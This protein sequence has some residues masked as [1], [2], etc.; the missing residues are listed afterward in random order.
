MGLE[1]ITD[2]ALGD[3]GVDR[4]VPKGRQAGWMMA[5]QQEFGS[6]SLYAPVDPEASWP[7]NLFPAVDQYQCL[8]VP[9][10]CGVSQRVQAISRWEAT[11]EHFLPRFLGSPHEAKPKDPIGNGR[12]AVVAGCLSRRKSIS[13]AQMTF[14]DHSQVWSERVQ[15]RRFTAS[16][17]PDDSGAT[18]MF[19][20]KIIRQ[21]SS[22]DAF[23]ESIS[24]CTWLCETRREWIRLGNEKTILQS[25]KPLALLD[26]NK[27]VVA[28][29]LRFL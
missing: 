9:F 29:R 18:L 4:G 2:N 24:R 12:N 25:A 1:Q 19:G 7:T 13:I 26:P 27:T 10:F 16:V 23:G 3:F 28:C 11:Q 21:S 22:G 6:R 20:E 15:K 14:F 5:S 17:R 8:G